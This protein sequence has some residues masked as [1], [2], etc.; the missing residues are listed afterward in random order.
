MILIVKIMKRKRTIISSSILFFQHKRFD[1]KNREIPSVLS[2][3]NEGC[4]T[5][6]NRRGKIPGRLHFYA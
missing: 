1:K 5:D 3:F 6:M 2:I 4:S